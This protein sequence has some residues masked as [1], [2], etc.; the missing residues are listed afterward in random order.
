MPSFLLLQAN[1]VEMR[2]GI[3]YDNNFKAAIRQISPYSILYYFFSDRIGLIL[4]QDYTCSFFT[5]PLAICG[6]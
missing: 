1:I 4:L 6:A 5:H 2:T 3:Y